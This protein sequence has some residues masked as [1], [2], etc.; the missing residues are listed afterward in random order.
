VGIGKGNEQGEAIHPIEEFTLYV[1]TTGDDDNDGRSPATP[2]ATIQAALDKIP[3]SYRDSVLIDVGS[4]TFVGAYLGVVSTKIGPTVFGRIE[5]KGATEL[6]TLTTGVNTGTASAGSTDA[7]GRY[8]LTKPAGAPDWTVDE[9]IGKRLEVTS[10]TGPEFAYIVDNTTDTITVG[11]VYHN[12]P[13]Y[14]NTSVFEIRDF[15]TRIDQ[16]PADL[17]G[18]SMLFVVWN[19]RGH[20]VLTDLLI[21]PLDSLY[22][23]SVYAQGI[24]GINVERCGFLGPA[25]GKHYAPLNI[26]SVASTY[27]GECYFEQVGAGSYGGA[28]TGWPT[29]E[30]II[31]Y[32]VFYNPVSGADSVQL[33]NPG[34]NSRVY[35]S[36]FDGSSKGDYALRLEGFPATMELNE[37]YIRDYTDDAV[38]LEDGSVSLYLYKVTIKECVRGIDLST[39][40]VAGNSV[41]MNT[42]EISDCSSDAMQLFSCKAGL[43]GVTGT[44]N[45]GYGIRLIALCEASITGTVTVT[46]TAGD[47]RNVATDVVYATDIPNSGDYDDQ[48]AGHSFIIRAAS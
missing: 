38:W 37:V 41:V 19:A 6:A 36:Y 18:G 4:G 20:L 46:G 26:Y 22:A 15:S 45:T 25:D 2:V 28:V 10:G 32:C 43:T 42:V 7:E 33:K 35:R 23:Q 9:L 1:R 31:G 11:V 14:D 13:T 40:K 48:A 24:D 3:F 8:T 17:F 34:Y 5:I 29:G 44:G 27:V 21:H 47:V 16:G 30:I 12:R 39:S